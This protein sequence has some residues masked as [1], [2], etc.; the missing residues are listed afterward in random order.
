LPYLPDEWFGLLAIR[1][2]Q[3]TLPF[4]NNKKK[5]LF[6]NYACSIK[7]YLISILMLDMSWNHTEILHV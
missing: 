4:W 2:L 3:V 5:S 1:R 6:I 7:C